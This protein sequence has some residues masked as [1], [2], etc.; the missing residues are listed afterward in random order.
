MSQHGALTF[1]DF[2]E[3]YHHF[4][5]DERIGK[6]FNNYCSD[7]SILTYPELQE[8][9]CDQQNDPHARD[10]GYVSSLVWDFVQR[11]KN[12]RGYRDPRAPYLTREEV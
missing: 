9:F 2:C 6:R 5:F 8:F 7:K 10:N 4:I 1:D 12:M 11:R 3:M